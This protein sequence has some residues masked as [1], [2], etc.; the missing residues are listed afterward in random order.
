M[1]HFHSFRAVFALVCVFGVCICNAQIHNTFRMNGAAFVA[2]GAD[3][4]DALGADGVDTVMLL[5][6]C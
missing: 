2:S 4:L 6:Q 3:L 1:K 5:G